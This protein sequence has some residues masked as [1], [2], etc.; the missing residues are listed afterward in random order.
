MTFRV[1]QYPLPTNGDLS[2]LN[3]YVGGHRV[4]TVSHHVVSAAGSAMLVF[5]VETVGTARDKPANANA[6]RVT[7]A[8]SQ[9][10][11]CRRGWPRCLPMPRTVMIWP[12]GATSWPG[13]G[14]LSAMGCSTDQRQTE[15]SRGAA[16]RVI[17]GGSWINSA[18]NCRSSN[19]NRNWPDNR[20]RN[21]G[22]KR[23]FRVCL[24]RGTT[25]HHR[26][27]TLHPV[28]ARPAS[29]TNSRDWRPA[30]AEIRA[31]GRRRLASATGPAEKVVAGL[32]VSPRES[33][34]APDGATCG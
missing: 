13:R 6:P 2:E 20:N 7:P 17:R 25:V 27:T 30:N 9:T 11:N 24:V 3:A 4:A 33:R 19:R 34:S 10:L 32:P 1:F 29:G 12:G 14:M 5:V 26:R 28:P 16:N 21:L 22:S 23:G 8:I 15:R 31:R 18:R